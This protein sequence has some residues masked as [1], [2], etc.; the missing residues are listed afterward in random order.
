MKKIE[1]FG[2]FINDEIQKVDEF[3]ERYL[4]DIDY[5]ENNE[6]MEY[7]L[8]ILIIAMMSMKI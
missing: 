5:Y 3:D 1:I 2:D 4:D 7:I 6:A 8:T